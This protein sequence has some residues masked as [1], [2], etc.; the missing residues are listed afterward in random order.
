M[1]N[2]RFQ[3]NVTLSCNFV[4][5]AHIGTCHRSPW[6]TDLPGQDVG[7]ILP[8]SYYLVAFPG[9]SDSKGFACNAG[10]PGWSI[11]GEDALEKGMATH[12]SILAWRIPRTEEPGRIQSLQSRRVG[13]DWVN[14]SVC[15]SST[16]WHVSFFCVWFF[17]KQACLVLC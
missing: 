17:Y 9:G 4:F 15:L 2:L 14:L 6:F 8:L 10:D 1:I 11:V 12:S 5:S 13:H 16:W 3:C 7:L